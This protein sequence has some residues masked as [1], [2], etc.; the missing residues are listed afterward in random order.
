MLPMEVD[1]AMEV[2]VK[3]D[4]D[5]VVVA[6]ETQVKCQ[7]QGQNKHEKGFL[8]SS[9]IRQLMQ[10]MEFWRATPTLAFQPIFRTDFA[11]IICTAWQ[12]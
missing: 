10:S 3:V 8:F 6:M 12:V 9:L 4:E 5:V 7:S 11:C 1:V 2:D